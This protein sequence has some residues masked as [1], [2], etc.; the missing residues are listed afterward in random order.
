MCKPQTQASAAFVAC[1][2]RFCVFVL[3]ATNAAVP[4]KRLCVC[5]WVGG[6][7]WVWVSVWLSGWVCVCVWLS[8]WVCVS[9][10]GCEG[11]GIHECSP[12]SYPGAPRVGEP[13]RNEGGH[14]NRS[15]LR[16]VW[17]T[18]QQQ[19][20]KFHWPT[21]Q[22]NREVSLH[23]SAYRTS[24]LHLVGLPEVAGED[25]IHPV[26]AGRVH[27]TIQ[28]REVTRDPRKDAQ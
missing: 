18:G 9:G 26:S 25:A 14:Q 13:T 10:C 20:V 22:L 6:C 17:P 15:M 1:R 19:A 27:M 11:R 7:G 16:P 5:M 24:I 2:T 23:C 4:G 28:L 21:G 12:C 3:Q 8:G